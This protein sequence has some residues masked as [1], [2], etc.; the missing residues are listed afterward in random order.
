MVINGWKASRFQERRVS[1]ILPSRAATAAGF[2]AA[3]Q[4]SLQ[5]MPAWT[6]PG[7]R[8]WGNTPSLPVQAW[9]G[10]KS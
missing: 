9:K 7:W 5:A 6:E 2:D 3:F 4:G 10:W 1:A 8:T